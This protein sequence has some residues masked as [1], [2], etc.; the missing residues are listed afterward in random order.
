MAVKLTEK[1]NYM[2]MMHG[3]IPEWVPLYSFGPNP[4]GSPTSQR[5]VFSGP[6]CQQME[7]GRA[8]V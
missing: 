6:L 5:K 7:I 2:R 4:D 3:E 1:E 8:H